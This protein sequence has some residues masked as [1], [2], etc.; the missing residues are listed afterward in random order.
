MA[1]VKQHT[2]VDGSKEGCE[3]GCRDGSVLGCI[4]GW[5]E[6]RITG[7][8]LGWVLGCCEGCVLG[9]ELGCCEG[10]LEGWPEECNV[11]E[12]KRNVKEQNENKGNKKYWSSW[13]LLLSHLM[14]VLMVASSVDCLAGLKAESL[15]A[16]CVI[17]DYSCEQGQ[18]I[19]RASEGWITFFLNNL[20]RGLAGRVDTR[21]W[22]GLW[23][24]LPCR[25]HRRLRCAI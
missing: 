22:T 14:V 9:C 6:G 2:W 17:I 19:E 3:L 5:A 12:R 23:T 13:H 21:L 20:P 4:E 11:M 1:H 10:W 16:W 25:L 24:R 8:A 7:C 15:V 18:K